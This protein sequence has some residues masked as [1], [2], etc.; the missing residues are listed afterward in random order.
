MYIPVVAGP[1]IHGGQEWRSSELGLL[2]E[3]AE[4]FVLILG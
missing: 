1:E 2:V 3:P 4:T